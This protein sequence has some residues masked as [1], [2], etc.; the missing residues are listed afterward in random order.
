MKKNDLYGILRTLDPVGPD[1]FEGLIARLL[2]TLT[3]RRFFLAKSGFQGGRDMSTER[4]NANII[5]VECKRYLENTELNEREI[6]GELQQVSL[7]IPD[8]DLWVL[9]ASR[10][11]PDRLQLSIS[12]SAQEKGFETIIISTDETDGDTPS[13]LAALCANAPDI[14]AQFIQKKAPS[15]NIERLKIIF[16]DITKQ[17]GYQNVINKL[18]DNFSSSNIGYDN[19]RYDQN[20][21]L[22]DRFCFESKSRAAFGQAL[23]VSDDN[24]GLVNREEAEEKLDNWLAS[25]KNKQSFYVLLGEEGDGKTWATASWLSK[26]LRLD[27][28]FPAVVFL[29][30]T[31]IYS[32]NDPKELLANAIAKQLRKFD[33]KYWENRLVKWMQRPEF[34]KPQIIIILD[35]I[36]ERHDFD[37]RSLME[38]LDVD[39]WKSRV[40]VILTCRT[41]T[42]ENKYALL[43]HLEVQ[44]WTIPFYNDDEL[45]SAL[46]V[47]D[48]QLEDIHSALHPLI[49]K[50]RYFDLVIKHRQIMAESGDVTIER[51]LYEDWRDRISRKSGVELG[52]DEFHALIRDLAQITLSVSKS[53]SIREVE[54]LLPTD[55]RQVVQE[56]IT[57]GILISD[58]IRQGKYKVEPR[59]LIHGLGLLLKEEVSES[60]SLGQPIEERIARLLEPHGEMDIKVKICGSAVLHAIMDDQFPDEGRLIL[61]QTWLAGRNLDEEDLESV[62]A[63]LPTC[64]ETYVRLAEHVWSD[65]HENSIAQ[66]LLM[67][68]FLKWRENERV[69]ALFPSAL[70]R[71][72]GFVHPL[73]FS[74]QRGTKAE[75]AS[76]IKL[77]IERRVG[78]K[79]QPG[80]T[81][82]L[83]YEFTVIE[84]DGLLRLARVALAIISHIRR[85]PF[86]KA[87]V[88]WSLSRAIMGYPNEYEL[89]SWVLKTTKEDI[90]NEFRSEVELLISK[91]NTVTQQAAA[92]LLSCKGSLEAN[93]LRQELPENLF[94]P[95]PIRE[96]YFQDPCAQIL[97]SWLREDYLDCLEKGNLP[98]HRIAIGMKALSLEPGLPV[99]KNFSERFKSL[100]GNFSPDSIWKE[101]SLTIEDHQLEELEP[102]LAA[103]APQLLADFVK[104]VIG[105]ASNREGLPLRHLSLKIKPSL[106]ILGNSELDAIDHTWRRIISQ[107]VS[108]DKSEKIAEEFLFFAIL[109]SL[110][111]EKQLEALLSRP[112]DAPD[113]LQYSCLFKPLSSRYVEKLIEATN[114]KDDRTKLQRILWFLSVNP[115]STFSPAINNII[116]FIEHDDTVIRGFALELAYKTKDDKVL[117]K[118]INSE[119]AWNSENWTKEDYWGSRIL[120]EF[121]VSLSYREIRS[122]VH[123]I[124]LGYAIEKR[125]SIEDEVEQY[126]EDIHTIWESIYKKDLSL[127][128]NFP[129]AEVGCPR[130]EDIGLCENIGISSSAFSKSFTFISRDSF[131]GGAY[132]PP[133]AES[134]EDA[135]NQS[136]DDKL[137]QYT[138][139]IRKSLE[140][141]AEAGNIWFSK[142]FQLNVLDKVVSNRLDLVQKWLNVVYQHTQESLRLLFSSQSFYEALLRVLIEIDPIEASKLLKHLESFPGKIRYIDNKT[143]IPLLNYALFKTSSHHEIQNIWGERFE[144]CSSDLELFELSL[145]F[146]QTGNLS[147]LKNMIE[148]GLKSPWQFDQARSIMLTGFLEDDHSELVLNRY[149]E[150]PQFWLQTVAEKALNL[151]KKNAWAKHWFNR[152]LSDKDDIKA[153]A[154]F[155]L[156]LKCVDRRFWIWKEYCLVDYNAEK[157][158]QP[159]RIEFL[160]L[161]QNEIKRAIEKNEKKRKETFLGEKV[162]SNQVWPWMN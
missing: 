16:E 136:I 87:F 147:W 73:G 86:I 76:K 145:I 162:L 123:P 38:K 101:M 132:H 142:Q 82:F 156:F 36:N 11:V 129:L 110:P 119:W 62:P 93:K 135:F 60:I 35:G 69:Q 99:P 49:R 80:S 84:D 4:R 127:P 154:C 10:T 51:L 116:N 42:W 61:F 150:I 37:W 91:K 41:I 140:K 5:S 157:N 95:N 79:L 50:P 20:K 85:R 100:T 23:N 39:P 45:S 43:S 31:N 34:E 126:A 64:P 28:S 65:K 27:D 112:K 161:N 103:F 89:V 153:W 143:G 141:Q 146:Q 97:Y 17:A 118:I 22:L 63:Y 59:R 1:G 21:W 83:G 57:S 102:V 144:K 75:K 134:V 133:D 15:I 158:K 66:T 139:I 88:S 25:W 2:E 155:R 68:G 44:S 151:W 54:R 96:I 74:F 78:F 29:T 160:S 13:L 130:K 32:T 40:G 152:F 121:G 58:K 115:G 33:R 48:L 47:H 106:L 148:K 6:L 7:A 105:D 94:P 149:N 98:P 77:E 137:E 26:V 12:Q 109:F 120:C 124:Y 107:K 114:I 67:E 52:H 117:Q 46:S 159:N 111:A 8:L 72:M 113:L 122:R 71:W 125:G 81:Q 92:R 14:V 56:L 131:W 104:S 19:W 24:V 90:W 30:S 70:L 55:H 53:F 9:V 128:E 138:S 18:T 3:E 108:L